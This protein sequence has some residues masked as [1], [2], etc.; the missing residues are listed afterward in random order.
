MLTIGASN[1]PLEREADRVAD[2][3]MA[4]PAHSAVSGAPLHIQRYARQATDDIDTAPASVDSVLASPGNPLEKAL[5]QDMEQRFGYDFSQIR[6]HSDTAAEL[7]ARDVSAHAYTAGRDIVFG[8]GQFTQGTHEGR[9]LIAHELTHVVQQSGSDGLRADESNEKRGL[10]PV[11][12]QESFVMQAQEAQVLS[13]AISTIHPSHSKVRALQRYPASYLPANET[14]GTQSITDDSTCPGYEP[15]E[16]EQS[17]QANYQFQ[18]LKPGGPGS[19]LPGKWL[20]SGFGVAESDVEPQRL[21]PALLDPLAQSLEMRRGGPKEYYLALD[22]VGFADCAGPDAFN[23]G[24]KQDRAFKLETAVTSWVTTMPGRIA[25]PSGRFNGP[26]TADAGEYVAPGNAMPSDRMKNRSV[27]L[28]ER[29]VPVP[30]SERRPQVCS[31]P[32]RLPV[33]GTPVGR[34]AYVDVP[35]THKRYAVTNA[36]CDK[37]PNDPLARFPLPRIAQK[38]DRSID[39]CGNPFSCVPC[40][41]MLGKSVPDTVQCLEREYLS[42][43]NPSL[44]N[45]PGPNSNTFAKQLASTCCRGIRPG[46]EPPGLGELLGWGYNP[47]A[48]PGL[49]PNPPCSGRPGCPP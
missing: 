2:R 26:F 48:W 35:S 31:R 36:F 25:N 11:F 47:A 1:D 16:V 30:D 38:S 49:P 33:L 13:N 10:S 39:P 40:N 5:R 34:H 7:S 15:G 29:W 44:Y 22:F 45:L 9:R 8:A 4:V 32:V 14:D 41:P 21:L 46:T 28:S 3:V 17:R 24:V 23:Q 43:P 18:S 20:F 19:P 42:Y 12:Q 27:V 6:V 37:D